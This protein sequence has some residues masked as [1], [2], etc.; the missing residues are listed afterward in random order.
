MTVV[1]FCCPVTP[2]WH[3]MSLCLCAYHLTDKKGSTI[4]SIEGKISAVDY[5]CTIVGPSVYVYICFTSQILFMWRG[6]TN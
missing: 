2:Q 4:Y 3:P 1:R 5:P 6:F